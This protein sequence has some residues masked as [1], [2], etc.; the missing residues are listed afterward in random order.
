MLTK[1]LLTTVVG[2]VTLYQLGAPLIGTF[3]NNI[4]DTGNQALDQAA[5][6]LADGVVRA[7]WIV[8][9]IRA[10][11]I[12]LILTKLVI[13]LLPIPDGKTTVEAAPAQ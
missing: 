8:L 3:F 5:E 13:P 12:F 4:P 11:I 10:V 2:Y 9:A 1:A 6:S 7:L